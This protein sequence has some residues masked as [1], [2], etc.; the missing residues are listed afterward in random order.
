[1][2][3]AHF[4]TCK[5]WASRI[6]RMSYRTRRWWSW[7]LVSSLTHPALLERLLPAGHGQTPLV[8]RFSPGPA[9]M[10]LSIGRMLSMLCLCSLQ[11]TRK[12]KERKKTNA[13]RAAKGMPL[14]YFPIMNSVLRSL[15]TLSMTTCRL[16]LEWLLSVNWI[17]RHARATVCT[18]GLSS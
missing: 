6:Y 3:P 10:F 11:L 18:D 15:L 2:I 4:D 14:W 7:T 16:L 5:C 8:T 17:S 9:C 12:T 13:C 1:M